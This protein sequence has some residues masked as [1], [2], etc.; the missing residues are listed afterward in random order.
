DMGMKML[1]VDFDKLEG[2]DTAAIKCSYPFHPENRGVARLMEEASMAVV[3]R[4]CEQESCVAACPREALEKDEKG[5]LVRHNLRCIGCLS[6]VSACPFGTLHAG[7]LAYFAP[8]CDLCF[9]RGIATPTC[10]ESSGGKGVSVEEI[11]GS[12]EKNGLFV[13]D[14]RIGK[15]AVR[16]RAWTKLESAVKK[17]GQRK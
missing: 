2:M 4:R 11:E 13:V 14:T 8:G 3:C 10:V 17:E 9:A 16:S 5:F 15:L 6:C 7:G 1:V 12:D